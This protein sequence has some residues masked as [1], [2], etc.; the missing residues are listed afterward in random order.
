MFRNEGITEE[1]RQALECRASGV[2][3]LAT[4]GLPA[5]WLRVP[6]TRGSRGAMCGE[7]NAGQ[8]AANQKQNKTR[9]TLSQAA[10]TFIIKY[11]L[12]KIKCLTSMLPTTTKTK[13]SHVS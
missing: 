6:S 13:I 10:H 5:V 8:T 9:H 4:R 11:K 3:W 1:K 12:S 7:D 2:P